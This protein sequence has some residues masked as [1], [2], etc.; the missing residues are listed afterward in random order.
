MECGFH[1]G[2]ILGEDWRTVECGFHTGRILGEDW[3]WSAAFTQGES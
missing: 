2:R 1:T 3:R